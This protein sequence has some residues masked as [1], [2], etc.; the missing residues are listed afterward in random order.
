MVPWAEAVGVQMNTQANAL[1]TSAMK[2]RRLK[3]DPEVVR[4]RMSGGLHFFG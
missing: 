3:T 2:P 1:M 4:I